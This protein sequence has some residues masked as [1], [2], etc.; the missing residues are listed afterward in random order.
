MAGRK[1]DLEVKPGKLSLQDIKEKL[2]K[3]AG[4][5]VAFNL[6]HDDDPSSVKY[7]IPT[8]SD[9]LDCILVRGR[10]AGIPSG[11]I[12]ELA[13][14][15]SSGKS[16]MAAQIAGN[17]QK[18]DFKVV[19]FDAENAVDKEF[20]RKSGIN[21]DEILYVHAHS[22]EF[23]F[24]TI[25]ELL[26]TDERWL[27]ILDSLAATPVEFDISKDNPGDFDPRMRSMEKAAIG[28][29]GF[30]K[31]TQG[32]GRTNSTLLLLNQLRKNTN[33]NDHIDVKLNP[34]KTPGGSSVEYFSSLRI[35]LTKRAG[36]DT[37]VR[38]KNDYP[39]GSEVKVKIKKSRFG[40][41]GRECV[42]GIIWADEERI[43]IRNEESIFEA[44]KNTKAIEQGG[45]WYSLI[46]PKTGEVFKF[47]S[48][49][50]VEKMNDKDTKFK[51]AVNSALEEYV[52]NKFEKKELPASAF[53]DVDNDEGK[54][55]EDEEDI[56]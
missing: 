38:D 44:I 56:G 28:A 33:F 16:Y 54:P 9:W 18:L 13:G 45:A 36:K 22:L 43:G 15:S 5:D 19:Y 51:E 48:K 52:I 46:D 25:E 3:K 55:I 24:S 4:V 39:I 37:I 49:D 31:I 50:F 47:Q 53:Y 23:V 42:F 30:P 17:A 14:L 7:W 26:Q 32:L 29:K 2:N 40:T 20:W 21:L 12:V 1:K 10:R 34:Y 8:G 27:F 35:W 11:K 41:E 6:L